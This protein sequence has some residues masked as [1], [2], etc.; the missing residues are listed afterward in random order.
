MQLD[1]SS[2]QT[3]LDHVR[4]RAR[5]GREDSRFTRRS[6]LLMFVLDLLKSI[7]YV[8]LRYVEAAGDC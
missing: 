6:L 5:R 1:E 7:L 8:A 4:K 3:C 2:F